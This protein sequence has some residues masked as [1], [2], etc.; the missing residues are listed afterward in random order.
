MLGSSGI[1][2]WI[3]HVA[4]WALL[5]IGMGSGEVGKRGGALFIALWLAGYL[6]LP[7]VPS[8]GILLTPYLAVLDIVLVFVVFKGDVRLS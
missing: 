8:G 5:L 4:F 1:A 2:A 7:F 3:A 6:G